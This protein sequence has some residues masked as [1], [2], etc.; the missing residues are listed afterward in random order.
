MHLGID[1]RAYCNGRITTTFL[2]FVLNSILSMTNS[3]AGNQTKFVPFFRVKPKAIFFRLEAAY[4]VSEFNE[5]FAK[6]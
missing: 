2:I 6:I 3:A 1:K 4:G 5:A